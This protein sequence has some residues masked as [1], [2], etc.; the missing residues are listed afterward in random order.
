[1]D[2]TRITQWIESHRDEMVELLKELIA[3]RTDNPPGNEAVAA[4]VLARYFDRR[5]IPHWSFEP[6]PGR[7]SIFGRI[8][9]EGGKTLLLPGHLDTVPAGDGWTLPPFE[10]TLRDG[11]LYGRGASD[12]KGPTAAIALAGA[13]LAECVQLKGAVIVA[14]LADEERGST[15]GLEYLLCDGQVQADFAIVPDIAGNMGTIDVAEKGLLQV[16]IVSHGVQAHASTPEKGVNA[17]WNL[18]AVLEKVRTR[19]IPSARHALLTPPT[20][21]LGQIDGGAAPNIVPAR[22]SA[23]IDMRYLPSQT[24]EQM[25]EALRVYLRE[26]EQELPGARFEMSV[27]SHLPATEVSPKT[28]MVESIQRTAQEVLGRT[29]V[30]VG[31]GGATLAKQLTVHGIPA[32]GFSAG[33]DDQAHMA[34]ESIDL[35]ELVQY[36]CIIAIVAVRLLGTK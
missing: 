1:M 8:G 19:G 13:C 35:D 24:Q 31:I 26:A 5:G 7:T 20:L 28:P 21:N 16:S 30:L 12:D 9:P 14:G 15:L 4:K 32:V 2:T 6:E 25:L 29:P 27:V 36:A 10:P 34:D 22:A 33:D 11:R 23:V 17:I 18:L 3:A